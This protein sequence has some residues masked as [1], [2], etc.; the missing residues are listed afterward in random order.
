M[1]LWRGLIADLVELAQRG[2]IGPGCRV[3]EIGEQQLSDEFLTADDLA[4]TLW[5]D[6]P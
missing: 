3:A 4:P 1:G 5:T 6:G 2:Y